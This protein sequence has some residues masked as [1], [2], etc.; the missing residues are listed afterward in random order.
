MPI[1][2]TEK[3]AIAIRKVIAEQGLPAE[4]THLR[5]GVKG[6]GCAGFTYTLDLSE[7]PQRENDEEMD[8]HG[9]RMLCDMSSYLYLDGAEI[10]Y[11]DEIGGV[12]FVFRNPN[13]TS[14]C[15]CSGSTQ[16]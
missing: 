16:A 7:E 12:G 11:R 13:P 3:A 8:S 2:L 6:G 9:V 15:G 5:V 4:Q 10:D 14:S 1:S